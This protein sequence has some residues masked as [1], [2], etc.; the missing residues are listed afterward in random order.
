MNRPISAFQG[1]G[2]A[3]VTPFSSSGAI[4]YDAYERMISHVING[5]VDYIVAMGTTGE[6]PTLSKEEKHS[7]LRFSVE[8]VASRVPLVIG[9]GGNNT[10]EVVQVIQTSPLEGIDGILSVSPYYNKPT[11]EGIYLHF[12]AIAESSPLPVILYTVPGR[13][14]GNISAETTIRLATDFPMI[15][16]IKEASGNLDQVY[17]ILKNR[18]DNFL[19]ISG[20]D[21]LTLP[22]LAAGADGVISVIANA[23]P[24]KMSSMVRF[25]LAGD[26]FHARKVHF[27][28]IDLINALFADGSPGGIKALLEMKGLCQEVVRLPLVPINQPTRELIVKLEKQ[29]NNL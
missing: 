22:M 7:L 20:D 12:K 29:L 17:Q 10:S 28:L 4:D 3:I 13:T 8:K 19:V 1:T 25:G 14:G 6:T 21:G 16:G 15:A 24:E 9:I 23:Y 5:G 11:Q 26:F 27:Q 2:V 18:P